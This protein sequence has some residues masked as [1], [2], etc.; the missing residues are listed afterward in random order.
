MAKAYPK[1]NL[2]ANPTDQ[3]MQPTDQLSSLS[4]S[5]Q[6]PPPSLYQELIQP[7]GLLLRQKTKVVVKLVL[8]VIMVVVVIPL[9]TSLSLLE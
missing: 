4:S 1:V 6:S 5:S 7:K 9:S 3:L 2:K 8:T